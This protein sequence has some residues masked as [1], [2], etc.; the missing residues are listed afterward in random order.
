MPGHFTQELDKTV[1]HNLIT[2]GDINIAGVDTV[3]Y[4]GRDIPLELIYGALPEGANYWVAEDLNGDG[5]LEVFAASTSEGGEETIYNVYDIN[6]KGNVVSTNY[7]DY[8]E[9]IQAAA[10]GYGVEITCLVDG[11]SISI[12]PDYGFWMTIRDAFKSMVEYPESSD[13]QELA[14]AQMFQFFTR[15][16][17]EASNGDIDKATFLSDLENSGYPFNDAF[18]RRWEKQFE[19]AQYNGFLN[20]I[21]A[22]FE[23]GDGQA[24]QDFF[25]RYENSGIADNSFVI[26]NSFSLMNPQNVLDRMILGDGDWGVTI[27]MCTSTVTTNCVDPKAINDIWED[28]GRHIQVI[29]KG[30]EIPGLP[31]WLPLPG[32]M[33]LPTIGEIWDKVTGPFTDAAR[34]QLKDCMSKDDDGDGVNNT[35]SYCMENRDIIGIITKGLEDGA[36]EII[37]ATTEAVGGI[38]DKA[39]EGIDCVLNPID[40]AG[41]I[42]DVLEGV[43]GGADPTQPGLPPWMR[44]IIIGSQYGDEVLKELEKI[45][46]EDIDGDGVIGIDTTQ[47]QCWDGT[48]V[49][50][51][52]K[53]PPEPFDCTSIGKFDPP[54][55]ATSAQD[56]EEP[57]E[58]DPSVSSTDVNCVNPAPYGYCNDATT[59][60]DDEAG[61]NCDEYAPNGFCEDNVTP[62][63]NPDGTNCDE[64][65][66]PPSAEEQECQEQGR[67]WNEVTE[68]C[69]EECQNT[70]HVV[71]ADGNCG[72]EETTCDNG[73]T[74]ESGCRQCEDGT[75]PEKH[76]GRDC[77]QPLIWDGECTSPQPSAALS[78]V[79]QQ[80]HREWEAKCKDTH[81]PSGV[82]ITEDP[83]CYGQQSC[84]NNAVNYPDCNQCENGEH[85]DAHVDS[86]CNKPLKE[87]G[88]NPGDAC[89][90][91]E[92]GYSS[93]GVGVIDANGDCKRVGQACNRQS[94]GFGPSDNCP[95]GLGFNTAQGVIDSNGD[96]VCNEACDDP[97]REVSP[98]TGACLDSCKFG[99]KE[100]AE[101]NCTVE[102]TDAVCD[103]GATVESGCSECP[104]GQ[105]FSTIGPRR[106]VVTRECKED[107]AYTDPVKAEECGKVECPPDSEKPYADSLDQCVPITGTN[108]EDQDP[109][110][111]SDGQ[112]GC[113]CKQDY[114]LDNDQNSPTFGTCQPTKLPP[115]ECTNDNGDPSGATNYP[116]CDICPQGQD[117]NQK[118][119]C[120]DTT[121]EECVT[122]D[123]VPTGAIPPD[124]SE[125]PTGQDFDTNG[126]CVDT[127][128]PEVC[129]DP[130]AVNNGQDGPCECKPGF[131]KNAEGLC[132]QGDELCENGATKESGCD[133]CPDGTSVIEYEDG[134]CPS[135]STDTCDNG[136]TD[137]PAC[138]TCPEGQSMDEEGICS[139]VTPPPETGGGPIGGSL[140]GSSGMMTGISGYMGDPQ[141]LS[142]TEF[143]ITDFLAGLFSN[144]RG[145]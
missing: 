103:N 18:M 137:F 127:V 121:T 133:T 16:L 40:C 6:S 118:G 107:D 49:D 140:G 3:E 72:P 29:F 82:P 80:L 130:N 122:P 68:E 20:R 110:S 89:D 113:R 69:E 119:I 63:D 87:T 142:R 57:C 26:E 21:G 35:A 115:Q 12:I 95:T 37:D 84:E 53:C 126:I 90:L 144:L 33:K 99:W 83:D 10:S 106:C 47:V 23:E 111:E 125:C 14:E 88:T 73:A 105:T 42:K 136:A 38:V 45:F 81:C 101:G 97:N 100:D 41:K 17:Q 25:D 54:G 9:S 76:E 117:F 104:K 56:C 79:H 4:E 46:N 8:Q 31:E 120:V 32:I 51:P 85:P 132:F 109:N 108:C 78:F 5:F 22:L 55:G 50:D 139:G 27:Q 67:I 124:C 30:L 98:T 39:L 11:C 59:P 61:T 123:G 70:D 66:P 19:N 141:L 86:D 128:L 64:Y 96:C 52:D 112:G 44:A 131:T 24:I 143:P 13:E 102:D 145:N 58:F 7:Q 91:A 36:S 43:L 94:Y 60:K 2:R 134:I 48:V 116:A 92:A 77:N 65:E 71:L 34:E 1:L 15:K 28:F 135:G 114:A 75:Q 93:G 138:T 74:T 129:N 62:K